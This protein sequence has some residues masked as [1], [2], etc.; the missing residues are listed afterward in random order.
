MVFFFFLDSFCFPGRSDLNLPEKPARKP[1]LVRKS[2]TDCENGV[3][4][5]R[6]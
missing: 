5:E 3:M 4:S 2:V 1:G 6:R